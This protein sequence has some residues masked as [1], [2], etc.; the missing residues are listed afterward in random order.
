MKTYTGI[1]L[2][3]LLLSHSPVKADEYH[4]QGLYGGIHFNQSWGINQDKLKGYELIASGGTASPG[5]AYTI[6]GKVDLKYSTL[7]FG[8]NYAF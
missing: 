7:Q 2:T 3:S 8:M 4:W 5:L 6:N 1:I